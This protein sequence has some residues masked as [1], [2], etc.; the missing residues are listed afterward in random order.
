VAL[1]ALL[2]NLAGAIQQRQQYQQNIAKD[3]LSLHTSQ[4]VK[5]VT[6]NQDQALHCA[7]LAGANMLTN[8][9]SQ[10][11]GQMRVTPSQNSSATQGT[12]PQS[13]SVAERISTPLQQHFTSL[14]GTN[15]ASRLAA[16]QLSQP[17]QASTQDQS[18][19]LA[20]LA[21]ARLLTDSQHYNRSKQGHNGIVA[22]PKP[23]QASKVRSQGALHGE[24][25]KLVPNKARPTAR[26]SRPP[27]LVLNK[28]CLAG[29]ESG[30]GSTRCRNLEPG[31]IAVPCRARGMPMD[32]NPLVRLFRFTSSRDSIFAHSLRSS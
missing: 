27:R 3:F 16:Q 11:Q 23:L 13:S 24:K 6:N 31:T 28:A 2:Q 7:R 29:A 26:V 8:L 9:V 30:D 17:T 32:H 14:A 18:L 15:L 21:G 20:R 25:K 4:Q 5:Q 1:T 12:R 10:P 22:P 19:A